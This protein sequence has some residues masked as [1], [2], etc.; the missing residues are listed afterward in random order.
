[1]HG[2]PNKHFLKVILIIS[3]I[4][5]I[6]PLKSRR[7]STLYLAVTEIIMELI[8]Y[9]TWF[10]KPHHSSHQTSFKSFD[11]LV[12]IWYHIVNQIISLRMF[13]FCGK[14]FAKFNRRISKLE[15]I[16]NSF[17]LEETNLCS[18]FVIV[19]IPIIAVG[20]TIFLMIP[21]IHNY[22]WKYFYLLFH[23]Y[24]S[25]LDVFIMF[26][27]K[28]RIRQFCISLNNH[29]KKN[30]KVCIDETKSIDIKSIILYHKK[31]TELI[32]HF[33]G[34]FGFNILLMTFTT[35]SGLLYIGSRCYINLVFSSNIEVTVIAMYISMMIFLMVSIFA[36]DT[37][38]R[39]PGHRKAG[40]LG[41]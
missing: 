37:F 3:N 10:F 6:I 28:L 32:N 41:W 1:M 16:L 24:Q 18:L 33:N 29:T 20:C 21:S 22:T 17:W 36:R 27:F 34:I 31:I 19:S 2:I 5:L 8:F 26:S 9:F 25:L 35:C 23:L 15:I 12:Q 40:F 11:E 39:T 7:I 30:K 38:A 14:S 4:F 13:L